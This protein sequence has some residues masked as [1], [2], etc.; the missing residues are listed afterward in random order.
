[1]ES[2]AEATLPKKSKNK[3][4]HEIWRNDKDLNLPVDKQKELVTGSSEHKLI[5]K[6]I[7]KRIRIL[8]NETTEKEANEIN[9]YASR[10]QVEELYRTFNQIIPHS[11]S[12]NRK[13]N[14][15]TAN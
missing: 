4:T 13:R 6:I 9:E 11:K 1:M 7:K 3:H 5:T 14:A 12:I 15:N 8:R 2:A 10:R